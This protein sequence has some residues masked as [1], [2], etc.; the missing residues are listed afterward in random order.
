M[1]ATI[2][3]PPAGVCCWR[4][5]T[6]SQ[7]SSPKLFKISPGLCSRSGATKY[8]HFIS[9]SPFGHQL[10]T[11][12]PDTDAHDHLEASL[13]GDPSRLLV[14]DPLL[15]PEHARADRDGLA[16]HLRRVL[17]T[18][19]H[20]HDV[21]MDVR[22]DVEERGIDPLPQDLRL[23]RVHRHDAVAAVL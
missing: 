8:S 18:P 19:E 14:H 5:V 3:T 10:L 9:T 12:V 20:V 11:Y 21:D 16:R 1:Y 7:P 17:G 4:M 6:S 13:R 2:D 22:R 23:V 15:E